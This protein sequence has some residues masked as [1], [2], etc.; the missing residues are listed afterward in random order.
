NDP[1]SGWYLVD[2]PGY[3]YAS[4]A[5]T[6]RKKWSD[7]TK[8]YLRRRLNLM[9]LFVLIDS[10][11]D[12]QKIDLDFMNWLGEQQIAFGIVFTK[13]DKM[14]NSAMHTKI[15]AYKK[16]VLETWAELPNIYITEN[17]AAFDDE[18]TDGEVID[19]AR[20]DYIDEHLLAVEQAIQQGVPVKGYFVWSLLD[21]FEWS[22][23]Y[24]KRFGIVHVDYK[25]QKRTL[26]QSALAYK[27][28]INARNSN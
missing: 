12:A 10:R 9:Y 28:L 3:G 21:N 23:G 24:T 16:K 14:S 2:L 25:T 17:G 13:V 5:K 4:T 11:L 19:L 20:F 1:S 8:S 26:K 15:N 18:I 22:E 27:A 6:E 7:F